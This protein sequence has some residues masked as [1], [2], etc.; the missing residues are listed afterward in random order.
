MK[1]PRKSV[2]PLRQAATPARR[3]LTQ[4]GG[5]VEIWK[6]E[7]GLGALL[8]TA[9][10]EAPD[11]AAA[12]RH[13]HGFHSYPARMHPDTAA[14]LVSGLTTTRQTVL[15][16]FSG[17]GTVLVEARL[18]GRVAYGID[19]NPLAV[20]LANL[21][22]AGFGDESERE[23][24]LA[25]IEAVVEYADDRRRAKAGPSKPYGRTERAL[26][27]PHVLLELDGLAKGIK[28]QCP[29]AL[30][31]T[32]WLVLSSLLTKVSHRKSDTS[33]QEVERRLASGFAIRFFKKKA[34]EL[35]GRLSEYTRLLP[36][37]RPKTSVKIGDARN[38]PMNDERAHAIIT[39]PPYP[40]V[41]D[42]VE[43]H[44]MRLDWLG[45]DVKFLEQHEIGA[46]RH[47]ASSSPIDAEARWAAQI[48]ACL[49][50]MRR[51]LVPG[52]KA[53]LLIADS[54][55]ARSAFY[56]D[57]ALRDLAS[58]HGLLIVAGASQRREHYHAPSREAFRA[59]PRREHLI[60]FEP[61]PGSRRD[62]SRDRAEKAPAA[63]AQSKSHLDAGTGRTA[64]ASREQR[65]MS[66]LARNH[67]GARNAQQKPRKKRHPRVK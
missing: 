65:P 51:V 32:L 2:A 64:G 52:G 54:V 17:S 34:T 44:R 19:A 47:F 55:V 27:P 15:D 28:E 43:H 46:H 38:L 49:D 41:Y 10:D 61:S 57:R 63:A 62:S 5:K 21:K 4:L 35:V 39:S 9:L 23:L 50:E 33:G 11:E 18:L 59:A 31:P 20:M 45:L 24:L 22:L 14:R 12:M 42:Y 53:V 58:K 37:P 56:A 3:A 29:P 26:F 60:V 67:M 40:G 6:D 25:V 13:V 36:D 30:A 7:R 16:P 66:P 8:E 48:G 1:A